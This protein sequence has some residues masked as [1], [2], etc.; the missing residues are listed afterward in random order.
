MPSTNAV[1]EKLWS[2]YRFKGLEI[3]KLASY[4][5]LVNVPDAI[6][7]EIEGRQEKVFVLALGI[8]EAW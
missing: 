3:E 7:R 5:L 2:S 6:E 8:G 1:G 4:D